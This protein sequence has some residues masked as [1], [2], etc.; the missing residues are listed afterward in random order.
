MVLWPEVVDAVAP[1]P[2]LAAGGIGTGR[3]IAAALALGAQG[4][5]DRIDLAD[6]GRSA[7]VQPAVREDYLRATVGRHGAVARLHRQAGPHAAQRVDRR[8]GRSR[9]RPARSGCRC[10]FMV[11]ADAVARG[12]RYPDKAQG[13]DVRARSARSSAG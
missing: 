9:S 13:R 10:R 7:D 1:T 3:Q 5:V 8:V 11:T 4:V 12:H 2:V 6:D